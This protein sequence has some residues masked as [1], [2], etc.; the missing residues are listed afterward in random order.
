MRR[1]IGASFWLLPLVAFH[2]LVNMDTRSY[3]L[4]YMPALCLLAGLGIYLFC[5]DLTENRPRM[6]P[7]WFV[8][9]VALGIML[10]IGVFI[11]RTAPES[12]RYARQVE[13]VISYIKAQYRPDEAAIVQSDLRMFYHAVHYYLPEYP[14]HL[15]QQTMSPPRPSLAFPSPVRLND[16]VSRVIFLN[17]HARVQ[18][19]PQ[20]V[21]LPG[22]AMLQVLAIAPAERYMYFGPEGVWFAASP[23]EE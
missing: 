14:G 2:L 23:D 18:P 4:I 6:L 1:L 15:L 3:V 9:V 13:S 7:T 12:D 22:G 10:N 19:Q 11:T 20:L 5:A 16:S 17:P 8:V 21:E